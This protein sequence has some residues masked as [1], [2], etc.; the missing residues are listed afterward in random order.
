MRHH[1]AGAY[2]NVPVTWLIKA[3]VIT[4]GAIALLCWLTLC[5]LYW[6]G[7]WQL[8]YHPKAAIMQTPAAAGLS[9]EPVRFA[10]TETGVTQLTGWWVPADGSRFVVL[11]LHGADG[12]LSDTVDALAAL[13]KAGLTVFAIDYRG[14]GQSQPGRPSEK[15][16]LDD[17]NRALDFLTETRHVPTSSIVLCGEGLGANLAANFAGEEDRGFQGTMPRIVRAVGVILANPLADATSVIFS[18]PRSRLVPAHLL[19]RDRYDLD[20]AAR[21]LVTPSLWLI[22]QDQSGHSVGLPPAYQIVTA[23][24]MSAVLRAPMESDPNFQ[25]ELKRWLDDLQNLKPRI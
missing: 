15:Q 14:Y 3:V 11:Y 4:L 18:D 23:P 7:S 20:G 17:A 22:S 6:Q 24:K 25:M 21:Q 16:W 8:L 13:H 1:P 12:N 10:A 19:V 5:L 2:P 9:Y